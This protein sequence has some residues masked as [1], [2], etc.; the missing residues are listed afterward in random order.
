MN[1]ILENKGIKTDSFYVPP[2]VLREGEFIVLFL[3]GGGYFYDTEMFL[4]D[5]FCSTTKHK[6]VIIPKKMTFVAHFKESGFRRT[7]YPTTVGEYLRKNANLNDSFSKKIYEIEWITNKTKMNSLSGTPRRFLCLYAALSKTSDIVFDL[8]GVDP[9]GAEFIFKMINEVIKNGG[10][11]ILL[12]NFLDKNEHASKFIE[13]EW[14]DDQF[15]PLK[16]FKLSLNK[17]APARA[18]AFNFFRAK[19]N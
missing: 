15:P 9:Q 18:D 7:F 14:N 3:F 5:I 6:N 1:I 17:K 10:S 19:K 11:A 12:D 4:K 16:E 13:L 2:F 8:L